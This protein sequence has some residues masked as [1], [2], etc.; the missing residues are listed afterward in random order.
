VGCHIEKTG[1]FLFE[2]EG[3]RD[4]ECLSCH[5]TAPRTRACSRTTTRARCA[6]RAT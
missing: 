1:P 5:E 2:H 4:L 6:T 3:D